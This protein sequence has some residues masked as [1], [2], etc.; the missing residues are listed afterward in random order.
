MTVYIVVDTREGRN[1]SL[2]S[3]A[4]LAEAEIQGMLAELPPGR[5]RTQ[6]DESL[7]IE[8]GEVDPV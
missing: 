6:L 5:A 3:T 1:V 4:E 8:E 7:E 2:W